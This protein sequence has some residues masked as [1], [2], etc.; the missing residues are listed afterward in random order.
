MQIVM[1]L[2]Y[3]GL[4]GRMTADWLQES[5]LLASNI[6]L[7]LDAQVLIN[8]AYLAMHPGTPPLYRAG[9]RYEEEPGYRFRG[10][11]AEEFAAI[12]VVL[13]RG[14]GDCDDLAPWRCAELQSAGEPAT[15]RIQWKARRRPDGTA[16]PKL[17]HVLV[18]RADRSIEDPSAKL[19]M[20]DRV[21]A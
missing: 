11:P 17:Y 2:S 3:L 14:F 18:R 19:G 16:G 15:I 6:K 21:K 20:Y 12:P 8:R 10:A 4:P 9:V 13:A 5:R 1:N 7:L